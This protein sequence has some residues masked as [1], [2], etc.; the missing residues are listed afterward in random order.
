[1]PDIVYRGPSGREYSF[2]EGTDAE[3]ALAFID[4]QE[5]HDQP[6]S[7]PTGGT[8]SLHDAGAAFFKEHPTTAGLARGATS[9]LP[10]AGALAGGLIGRSGA[11]AAIG[12]GLGRGAEDLINENTGLAEPSTPEH[13]AASMA[14]ET[15]LTSLMGPVTALT[16]APVEGAKAGARGAARLAGNLA[17]RIGK[18]PYLVGGAG[19]AGLLYGAFRGDPL[20]IAQGLVT[21]GAAPSVAK[22]GSSLLRF[23]NSP[24]NER[25][26][27]Q[28][29]NT[30]ASAPLAEKD[31]LLASF[32]KRA[33]T[34]EQQAAVAEA[35]GAA[36]ADLKQF[37]DVVSQWRKD[38][39]QLTKTTAFDRRQAD[40][41]QKA[42]DAETARV[43]AN[44]AKGGM[45][46]RPASV[47]EVTTSVDGPTRTTVARTYTKPGQDQA[48][49]YTPEEQELL[50][51]ASEVRPPKAGAVRIGGGRI[52]PGEAAQARESS[53]V[54]FNTQATGGELAEQTTS[55]TNVGALRIAV[56]DLPKTPVADT[57]AKT[58]SKQ[59]VGGR[60][61]GR[62]S[63]ND[64][65]EL[66]DLLGLKT[67]EEFALLRKVVEKDGLK[68]LRPDIRERFLAQRGGRHM[69]LYEGAKNSAKYRE[70]RGD[71]SSL[72]F[73]K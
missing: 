36:S 69:D 63:E 53:G 62:F 49:P 41:A 23:A 66:G 52:S 73:E 27:L 26:I 6:A 65:A 68:S 15:A 43:E 25:F 64:V 29:T 4:G 40:I 46:A 30:L 2:P 70:M 59:A 47:R 19:T 72:P 14:K 44:A 18:H 20:L 8:P 51:R 33:Q 31:A 9:V 50:R 7:S 61:T 16:A 56:K 21:A 39:H 13:K 28:M 17:V 38:A 34:A 48:S 55:P 37:D 71:E 35:Q 11:G 1:M 60:G 32:G 22:I 57:I 5:P 10:F 3:E 58:T 54:P 45:E 42:A 67:G 12:A 24:A